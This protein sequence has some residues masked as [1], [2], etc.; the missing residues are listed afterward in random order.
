MSLLFQWLGNAL[1]LLF[2][3]TFLRAAFK[4]SIFASFLTLF[5][6][7]IYAY[8]AA[9]K[10]IIQNLSTAIPDVVAG[11]WGWVMPGNVNLC[12]LAMISATLLRFFTNLY[13]MLMNHKF[14][15]IQSI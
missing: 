10:A 13:R 14:K 3:K 2:G 4:I 7:A 5:Y 11:V 12:I 6:A 9:A 8:M 1:V 15:A